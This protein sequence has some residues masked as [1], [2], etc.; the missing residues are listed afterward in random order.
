MKVSFDGHHDQRQ[1]EAPEAW[2]PLLNDEEKSN[3]G[4]VHAETKPENN[5]TTTNK[6]ST[7]LVQSTLACL[8]AIPAVGIP[9]VVYVLAE[10]GT[11]APLT[12]ALLV[13]GLTSLVGSLAFFHHAK[14]IARLRAIS[15]KGFSSLEQQFATP[16][17]TTKSEKAEKQSL[18]PKANGKAKQS[19]I[20][21][22]TFLN[23][24][25]TADGLSCGLSKNAEP[26][27]ELFLNCTVCLAD[28]SGF[29]AWCSAREAGDVFCLLESLYKEFDATAKE[30]GVFKVE[31]VGDC[32]V[33]VTGLP[34]KQEDHAVIMVDFAQHILHQTAMI[35]KQLEKTL[36]P[37]TSDLRLRIGINSGPVTAGVLRG[38]RARFQLFGDTV[39]TASRME[40]T[41]D[42]NR[43][44]MTQ[45]TADLLVE[46]GKEHWLIPRDDIVTP[47]GK[48]PMRTFWAV[49]QKFS[50]M[51]ISHRSSM[52]SCRKDTPRRNSVT[53][54]IGSSIQ[55]V[56]WGNCGTG[57][58]NLI[59]AI[60]PM[61]R[62]AKHKRLIDW[63]VEMMTKLLKRI[64]AQRDPK[65]AN[66]RVKDPVAVLQKGAATPYE[67]VKEILPPPSTKVEQFQDTESVQ[68][69]PEIVAQLRAVITKVSNLYR[70]NPFH[71]FEHASHVTLSV[72]KLLNR[73]VTPDEL[74]YDG[75]AGI[76]EDAFEIHH[77]SY[78]ICNDALSHFA[79]VFSAL[80][81]D[82]DHSGVS[83]V[84]LAQENPELGEKYKKSI[85]EQNSIDISWSLLMQED[86]KELQQCIFATEEEL[87]RFR[88]TVVNCLLATD[89]FEPGQKSF[90]NQR[91]D[92]AFHGDTNKEETS[93]LKRTIVIEHI[94]QASDVSHTMQHW[95]IYQ[96]WNENLFREMFLAFDEG[97]SA[98]D[99]TDGWY[100]GELWFYDNYV[101]PLAKKLAECKVFGISSDEFLGYA[102]ENRKRWAQEG[103]HL[104]QAMADRYQKRKEMEIGGLTEEEISSFTSKDLKY[105]MKKQI[106]KGRYGGARSVD[107]GKAAKI[108]A[109]GWMDA[110]EIYERCPAQM[111]LRDRSIVFPVYSAIHP[112]LK[113]GKIKN[114]ANGFFEQ[115]LA[116]KFVRESKLYYTRDPIHYM[117]AISM[118]AE[119]TAM[120]G[121]C[122]TALKLVGGLKRIYDPTKHSKA[123][124]QTYGVDRASV[125]LAHMAMWYDYLG[126]APKALEAC[127]HVIQSVI[128]KL[129][130]TNTL[131]MF[132]LILPIVKTLHRH[133]HS[134]QSYHL[135]NDHI[136]QAFLKYHDPESFTPSKSVHQP[137][138]WLFALAAEAQG[139]NALCELDQV[140]AWLVEGDNGIPNEFLDNIEIRSS[141]GPSDMSA[142]LCLLAAQ[143]LMQQ[144]DDQNNLETAKTIAQKGLKC[145]RIADRKIRNATGDVVLPFAHQNH[146][147][148][149]SQVEDLCQTLGVYT[150]APHWVEPTPDVQVQLPPS[151]LVVPLDAREFLGWTDAE[152]V[153]G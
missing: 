78:G 45:E 25:D 84:Q 58:D 7:Q 41:S 107:P 70:D 46:G 115:N 68:L 11:F 19:R 61:S 85:A 116:R 9:A 15:D 29:T 39:N 110:L 31:T 10:A 60:P 99:P 52:S 64:V 6:A 77:Y 20:T 88:A 148:V 40:S 14:T 102:Q 122:D 43:I 137:A 42:R 50:A 47:K 13:A 131:G 104:V 118:L 139:G 73:V 3:G 24:I 18:I 2:L 74:E 81:H 113:G 109:Q 114:D 33:A 124:A 130:P 123:M 71:S 69:D 153:V 141:W 55:S 12:M 100:K 35:V 37:D 142:E 30:M 147:P 22:K 119:V 144:T 89:I 57:D 108:G 80:I 66:Q 146:D 127:H 76:D 149:L 151:Y 93:D 92:K 138:V 112:W 75:D 143:R 67:E 53:G 49:N 51:D 129:D 152:Y 59:T 97:R 94:I 133:G 72:H 63:N 23:N 101:I 79:I 82:V 128:P 145:A 44:Q 95:N 56:G 90:R 87:Q 125:A 48:R 120:A 105:I 21:M 135:F 38:D 54:S 28:I 4:V 65:M 140:V 17:D 8:Y 62:S 136:H 98:K 150:E 36:G 117:R 86:Y 32:Y 27:A 126:D 111:E 5:A 96:K 26:L 83:N 91:W 1:Q 103:E 134:L 121:D 132:D 106:A 34:K 16:H